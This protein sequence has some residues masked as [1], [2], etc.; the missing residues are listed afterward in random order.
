MAL[1]KLHPISFLNLSHFL[2]L[3]LNIIN[4]YL[5]LYKFVTLGDSIHSLT[6]RAFA[7]SLKLKN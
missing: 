6:Y 7:A 1:L 3:I 5:E 2:N 4:T